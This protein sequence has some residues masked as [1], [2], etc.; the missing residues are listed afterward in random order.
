MS[1]APSVF[2]SH[3]FTTNR[4]VTNQL[5]EALKKSGLNLNSLED[6]SA[7]APMDVAIRQMI[8][9]SDFVIADLTGSNPN[10]M[11][12][13]GFARG[14]GKSILPIVQETEAQVSPHVAGMIY[15]PYDPQKPDKMINY[16]LSW[17]KRR[18][19]ELQPAGI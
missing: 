7:T 2:I 10:V 17:V 6:T 3:P 15:V 11:F 5:A 1:E 9:R 8:E 13:V 16:V 14:L 19:P 12:E 18:Q 4:E